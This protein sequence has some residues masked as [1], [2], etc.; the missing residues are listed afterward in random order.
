MAAMQGTATGGA[1]QWQ[2]AP[3]AAAPPPVAGQAL[4]DSLS[5]QLEVTVEVV[6]NHGVKEAVAS[7]LGAEWSAAHQL[8]V[9]LVHRAAEGGPESEGLGSCLESDDASGC[10]Q[11]YMHS[12]RRLLRCDSAEFEVEH[13]TGDLWRMTP[14]SCF[15]GF[16]SGEAVVVPLLVEFWQLFETDV[17]P[18]WYVAAPGAD[19]PR[20]LRSMDTEDPRDYCAAITG[21]NWKRTV[22]DNNSLMGASTR[23]EKTAAAAAADAGVDA[24]RWQIFPTPL[25][26]ELSADDASIDAS[27]V[28]LS[29][30]P[31]ALPHADT[32]ALVRTELLATGVAVTDTPTEASCTLHVTTGL[33][34]AGLHAKACTPGGYTLQIAGG[35]DYCAVVTGYDPAGA[36]HGAYSFIA[37]L[38]RRPEGPTATL[39]Q[40]QIVDAPRFQ[41]RG[42]QV[43]DTN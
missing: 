36:L 17:M 25:S 30:A 15:A 6:S 10:W 38:S 8:R 14:T 21:S 7:E 43:R 18:R 3:M 5:S 28:F 22:A 23:F 35:G 16:D 39:P 11:L 41:Y 9:T 37:L 40:L 24:E 27:S 31:G 42:V 4:V 29:V 13:V 1:V 33:T 34:N 26:C 19:T 32:A 20:A 2:R 12:I